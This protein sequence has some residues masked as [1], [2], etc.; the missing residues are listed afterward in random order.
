MG[1]KAF[2]FDL[3]GTLIDSQLNFE[4]LRAELGLEPGSPILEAL[5]EWPPEKQAWAHQIVDQHEMNGVVLSQLYPGVN[6]FL[7]LLAERNIPAALF[8]RNSRKAT[9]A[10]IERH[11]F[12]FAAVITR[13]DAPPKPNPAGL[14][15]IAQQFGLSPSEILFIGDYLFDLKAGSAAQMPTAIFASSPVDFDI[16]GAH[17]LFQTFLELHAYCE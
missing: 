17:F 2:V 15:Q 16:E 6:E 13:D 14:L 1:F 5:A 12:Q 11:K 7:K 8:T 3:D 4:N 10:A 9:Q